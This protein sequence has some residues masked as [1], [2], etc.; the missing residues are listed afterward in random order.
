MN[1][2]NKMDRNGDEVG[3]D[4]CQLPK[5]AQ[6]PAPKRSQPKP[7]QHF[8][9]VQHG[10]KKQDLKEMNAEKK[11][12]LMCCASHVKCVV[13]GVN[14][15]FPRRGIEILW[16]IRADLFTGKDGKN[17]PREDWQ[18]NIPAFPN[19]GEGLLGC[20]GLREGR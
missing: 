6:H 20:H 18:D 3:K 14:R 1:I 19:G 7:V 11:E 16:D 13:C 9:D 15:G 4:K 5:T 12:N 10:K 8:G 17:K 2:G